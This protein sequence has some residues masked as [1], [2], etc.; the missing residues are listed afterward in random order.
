MRGLKV[1][2]AD[3]LNTLVIQDDNENNICIM[4]DKKTGKVS[5]VVYENGYWGTNPVVRR[6]VLGRKKIETLPSIA[7][8]NKRKHQVP[9]EE[10]CDEL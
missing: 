4:Q 6:Y 5:V 8:I 1:I 10:E 3:L 7:K 9:A 2:N